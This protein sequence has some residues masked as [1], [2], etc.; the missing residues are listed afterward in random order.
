MN[1]DYFCR[2]YMYRSACLARHKRY[3]I[4]SL[5]SKFQP[6]DMSAKVM[7]PPSRFVR[8]SR[9]ST[10]SSNSARSEVATRP[11]IEE[12]AFEGFALSRAVYNRLIG[13]MMEE[14][15]ETHCDDI[16]SPQQ[17]GCCDD[18]WSVIWKDRCCQTAKTP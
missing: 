6:C 5:T 2:K 9:L 18:V 15:N 7:N 17:L 10:N 14:G 12:G 8:Q 13:Q 16:L 4:Q 11:E 1:S 3:K